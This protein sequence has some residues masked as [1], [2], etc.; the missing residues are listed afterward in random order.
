M[1]P[2][3]FRWIINRASQ[4]LDN[5]HILVVR[6]LEM[7]NRKVKGMLTAKSRTCQGRGGTQGSTAKRE[8][9]HMGAAEFTHIC[10]YKC[11]RTFEVMGKERSMFNTEKNTGVM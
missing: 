11:W 1:V 3:N 7:P 4:N 5:R 9:G 6:K 10:H 2:S 8:E